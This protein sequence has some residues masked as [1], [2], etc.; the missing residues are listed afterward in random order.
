MKQADRRTL[1]AG[2]TAVP[3]A[4]AAPAV[5]AEERIR[6]RMATSWPKNLPGPGVAAAFI[7]RRVGELSGG[8]FEIQLFGAGEIVPAYGFTQAEREVASA[9]LIAKAVGGRA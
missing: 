9:G 2:L 8:R 1:L 6:W 3:A 5:R 4:L 7:A